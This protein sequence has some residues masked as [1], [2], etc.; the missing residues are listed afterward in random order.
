MIDQA[1]LARCAAG[2][3]S[4]EIALAQL[5]LSGH[6]PDPD[7]LARM[8]EP[9]P[10]QRLAYLAH[11]H[12]D[13]LRGLSDLAARGFSPDGPD[14]IAGAAALFDQ[15]AT[16]APEAGVAFYTF[17]DP[18]AFAAATDELVGVIRAWTPPAGKRVIDYG[19]GIGRVALALADEAADTL[20]IDVSAG[21]V[22]AARARAGARRVRFAQGNGRDLAG[23]SDSSADL[24]IAAD[25]WPF[26]VTA[27]SAAVEGMVA[28]VAR[29]LAPGGDFLLFNYSYRGNPD[30]DVADVQAL[31]LAHGFD[32]V[33]AGE[34]PFRIWDGVGFHLRGR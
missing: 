21:M 4:P 24:L 33:R 7:A 1:V 8:A 5:L 34:T 20:G 26:L 12:R 23:V 17:G 9:G 11:Q 16:E 29:V 27:G 22:A 25:I 15:L 32:V 28:E 10:L 19:C 2:A 31:A 3:I 6:P 30:Q 13:R 18:Q 14:P